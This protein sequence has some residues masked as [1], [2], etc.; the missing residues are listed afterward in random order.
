MVWDIGGGSMQISAL[1]NGK[2]ET[3]KGGLASVTFKDQIIKEILPVS[4]R[5]ATGPNPLS[6]AQI[7]KA[8]ILSKI[9]S[10]NVSK[11]IKKRLRNK[12]TKVIGIGG[13]HNFSILGQVGN[14]TNRYNQID[15][16]KTIQTKYNMTDKEIGGKYASTQVSNLALVLGHMQG[17]QIQKVE[18]AKINMT[19]GQLIE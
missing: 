12:K 6:Q 4:R 7:S 8:L 3:Y 9:S 17:L 14:K 19:D 2:I 10:L 16:Q 5:K 11:A 1:V 13:V 18:V 15:L